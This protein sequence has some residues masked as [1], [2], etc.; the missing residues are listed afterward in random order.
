M[1]TQNACTLLPAV[2]EQLR[3]QAIRL[4]QQGMSFVEIA[5]VVGVHRNTI[6]KWWQRYVRDGL[7][8]L[9]AQVRGRR[10]GVQRT[11]VVEE[12]RTMQRL[13]CDKNLDQYKLPF[14]LWTRQS[15]QELMAVRLK[16]RVPIRT[17]GEYLK[18]WGFTPQ[19]PLKRACEQRP[20]AVRQWLDED[21]PAIASRAKQEQAEIH[22][23]DETGMRNDSQHGRSSAPRRHTPVIRLSAKR[24]STNMISTVTNQGKV[25]FMIYSGSMNASRL[26]QFFKQ[27]LKGAKQKIFLVL[28]NLRVHYAKPV[29]AWLAE[30]RHTKWIEVFFLQ[31]TRLN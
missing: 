26:I 1:E 18:R 17:A 7:K 8:G 29:K 20:A 21:Y 28:D 2:Q 24:T 30:S 12:E 31:C 25:W 9:K 16:V 13:I 22:W 10:V 15:V 4:K 23:G 3:K 5:A 14:A 19:K 6:V 11:L 27:L